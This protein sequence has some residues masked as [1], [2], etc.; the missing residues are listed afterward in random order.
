MLEEP[1]RP[2]RGADRMEGN[3]SGVDHT[4]LQGHNVDQLV[5]KVD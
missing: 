4:E 2:G 1:G 5:R 3:R